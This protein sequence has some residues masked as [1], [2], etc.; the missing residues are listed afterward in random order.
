MKYQ[1]NIF[2]MVKAGYDFAD[3]FFSI[4]KNEEEDISTLF[5]SELVAN[6]YQ[7]AGLLGENNLT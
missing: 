7:E 6:A 2:E 4:F 3:D 1:K 5:C